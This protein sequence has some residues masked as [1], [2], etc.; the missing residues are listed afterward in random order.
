MGLAKKMH[1]FVYFFHLV[2]LDMDHIDHFSA[3]LQNWKFCTADTQE[4]TKLMQT[5]RSL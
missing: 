4:M 1:K 3:T 5:V 2:M